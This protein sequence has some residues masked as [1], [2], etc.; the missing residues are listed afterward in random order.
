MPGFPVVGSIGV[1]LPSRRPSALFATHNVERSH[2]G[3]TCCGLRPTGKRSTT[4]S[5]AGIDHV[6]V[7]GTQ[8]RDVDARQR[9]PDR[10]RQ[11]SC[12]R[13]AVKVR[14]ID[15]RRHAGNRRDPARRRGD[16][17]S[18][19]GRERCDVE[20]RRDGDGCSECA[21]FQRTCPSV[22]AP[23]SLRRREARIVTAD[24]ARCLRVALHLVCR[25][26]ARPGCSAPPGRQ[27]LCDGL[28]DLG[29]GP[30]DDRVDAKASE[31]GARQPRIALNA[32]RGVE[33]L[34]RAQH[35][36]PHER[37]IECQ[38]KRGVAEP[39][40]GADL[41]GRVTPR[42]EC[43]DVVALGDTVIV[44]DR[45]RAHR[46]SRPLAIQAPRDGLFAALV[47]AVVADEHDVA[48]SVDGEASRGRHE[49]LL[50]HRRRHAD[51]P[52]KTH[53][54]R[55]RI[56]VALGHIGDHRSDQRIAERGGD[57]SGEDVDP[58]VVLA[59]HHLRPVL[60]RPADGNDDRRPAR[61]DRGLPLRSSSTARRK[62]FAAR[63]PEPRSAR[64]PSRRNRRKRWR[65]A[66]IGA[67]NASR[68]RWASIACSSGDSAEWVRSR[69]S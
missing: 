10:G 51:R 32:V 6:D 58:H 33:A 36:Q 28:A 5:V 63:L 52:G 25:A 1:R 64:G 23:A 19:C 40:M 54:R 26:K 41:R 12:R 2:D 39:G 42:L 24:L 62:C 29:D 3:T 31:F 8:V 59:E 60:L 47:S 53:V 30:R 50:E 46:P 21:G 66:P 38:R 35:V 67:A 69:M 18:E 9:I 22:T 61:R 44:D 4:L 48:E 15:D 16:G 11:V 65:A 45:M 20:R 27:R 7:V 55:W 14:R 57:A 68:Q 13:F 49:R 17:L 56:D 43:V 34:A 37:G